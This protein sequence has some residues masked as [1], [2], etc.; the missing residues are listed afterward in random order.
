MPK[1]HLEKQKAFLERKKNESKK[2]YL[3]KE[4]ERKRLAKQKCKNEDG[5]AYKQ[6]LE[7]ERARKK[8]SYKSKNDVNMPLVSDD[9]DS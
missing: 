5:N 1:S 2:S 9:L 6:Y 7:K 3:A 8:D 4:R